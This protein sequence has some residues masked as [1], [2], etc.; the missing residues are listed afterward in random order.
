M[1]LSVQLAI[2]REVA[3]LTPRAR[4][5]RDHAAMMDI[6]AEEERLAGSARLAAELALSARFRDVLVLV[7]RFDIEPFFDFSAK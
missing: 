5:A 2:V 6:P 7:E 1:G 4:A 3:E